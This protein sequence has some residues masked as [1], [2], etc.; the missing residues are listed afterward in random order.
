MPLSSVDW[1]TRPKSRKAYTLSKPGEDEMERLF[2]RLQQEKLR[3][4]Y[5]KAAI[6]FG[7]LG[8]MDA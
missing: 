8:Q 2:A 3:V 7:T 6:K 4:F 1:V 5:A